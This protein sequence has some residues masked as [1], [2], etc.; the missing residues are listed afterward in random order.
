M[1]YR[2]Q[3]ATGAPLLSKAFVLAF[4]QSF[5]QIVDYTGILP[6]KLLFLQSPSWIILKLPSRKS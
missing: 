3:V 2:Q 1:L 6:G 5:A 4:S